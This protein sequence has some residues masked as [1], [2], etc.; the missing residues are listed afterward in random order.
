[1]GATSESS[2]SGGMIDASCATGRAGRGASRANRNPFMGRRIATQALAT[3]YRMNIFD[4]DCETLI[5]MAHLLGDLP[6]RLGSLHTT[7]LSFTVR[8]VLWGFFIHR[9]PKLSVIRP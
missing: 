9:M 3:R 5:S 2:C 1:M 6:R 7:S 4:L 8:C